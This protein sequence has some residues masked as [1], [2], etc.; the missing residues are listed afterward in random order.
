MYYRKLITLL[1]LLLLNSCDNSNIGG[2]N[3]TLVAE[4]T[5]TSNLKK[6]QLAY[7]NYIVAVNFNY[8]TWED[9]TKIPSGCEGVHDDPIAKNESPTLA[10]QVVGFHTMA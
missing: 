5:C 4:S 10:D 9:G 2:A 1:G 7:P 3:P 6:L 8:I